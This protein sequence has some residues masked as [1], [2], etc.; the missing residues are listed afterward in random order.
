MFQ[1]T[2]R[3]MLVPFFECFVVNG[4]YCRPFIAKHSYIQ[5]FYRVHIVADRSQQVDFSDCKDLYALCNFAQVTALYASCLPSLADDEIT[6]IAQTEGRYWFSWSSSLGAWISSDGKSVEV[7][8]HE[9]ARN[10]DLNALTLGFTSS[11]TG[12][13]LNLQGR[14]AIHANAVYFRDRAIA[15]VGAS[16]AGKSTLS[17]FC[18]QQEMGL[19]T[20]DV[21]ILD[22]D[23]RVLPGNPRL[24]L[25]PHTGVALQLDIP[26]TTDYKVFY[27]ARSLDLEAA[28]APVPLHAICL[29]EGGADV[30][31]ATALTI[32]ASQAIFDLLNNSY[33]VREFS[34]ALPRLVDRYQALTQTVPVFRLLYPHDFTQLPSVYELLKD[35]LLEGGVKVSSL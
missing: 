27:D 35:E 5:I 2:F 33:V 16:G 3:S 24:K 10:D 11:L 18:I 23:D 15:F 22:E 20:D 32:P 1:S 31:K 29:L 8:V 25:Y 17:T 21:L 19:L 14:V 12:A 6:A 9:D 13:C 30:S 7:L 34:D 28:P 4:F 26:E